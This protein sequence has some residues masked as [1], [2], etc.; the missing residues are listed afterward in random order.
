MRNAAVVVGWFRVVA[1]M[2]EFNAKEAS[3]YNILNNI[4]FSFL[5]TL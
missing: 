5:C 4:L 1:I 3:L 2:A